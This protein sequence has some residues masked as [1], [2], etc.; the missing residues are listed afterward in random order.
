VLS[1]RKKRIPSGI[2]HAVDTLSSYLEALASAQP[3][4]GGGSATT[5]VGACG[6]ALI[7]MVARIVLG[8]PKYADK[9]EAAHAIVEQADA[10]RAL[11][12]AGR[13]VDEAA[14]GNVVAATVLPRDTAEEKA[15]REAALQNALR[16]AASVPLEA[17]SLSVDVL[18]LAERCSQLGNKHLMSDVQCAAVFARA[19]FAA[20]AYNVRAN[21]AYLKDAALVA[22][23]EAQLGEMKKQLEGCFLERNH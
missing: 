15:A 8:N 12:L 17:A 4:P 19:G 10:L 22:A 5:V 13:E 3:V 14:Y 11:L 7:A 16:R 9:H 23:Q 21:H 6:A 18:K 2:A 20:A 1:P